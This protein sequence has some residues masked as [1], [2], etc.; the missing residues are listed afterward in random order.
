M[1]HVD[2]AKGIHRIEDAYTNWYLVESDGRLT[3]VDTGVPA[4]W[5]SL[6]DALGRLGRSPDDLAAIVL[7]HAHFDHVGFADRARTEYDLPVWVHERDVPLTQHPL[8]YDHES[9][10][11][12]Y[13]LTKPKALPII[14]ALAWSRAFFAKPIADVRT[15]VDGTVDVPG[16]PHVV[17]TPGHTYGHVSL[18]F[19]DR[20]AVIAGDAVVTL[21]PYTGER[22][23]QI[24]ARAATADSSM[25]LASLDE[26]A[27][28]GAR[29]VLTGHGEPW[30]GG[31][32]EIATRA[33]A[34][35][36]T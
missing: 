25:A 3:I 21:N 36:V 8:E 26:L 11:T 14:A 30:H 10:R 17:A 16:S 29:T 27:A 20:D 19:P 15:F 22:G 6:H 34:R 2:D 9:P 32:Q 5:D 18:H 33:R 4:S 7:T 24:V 31:A 28:T 12:R 13:L 35:G 1:L 23:P